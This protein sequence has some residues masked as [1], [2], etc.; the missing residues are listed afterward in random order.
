[1]HSLM[2]MFACL[3]QRLTS[4]QGKR[5]VQRRKPH[6]QKNVLKKPLLERSNEKNE[7]WQRN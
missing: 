1:M 6:V 7:K 3:K 5:N 4:K 2:M